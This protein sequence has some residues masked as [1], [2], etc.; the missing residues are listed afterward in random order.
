M[1]LEI[2]RRDVQGIVI[3]DLKG[4]LVFGAEDLELGTFLQSLLETGRKNI[5]LNL[6][7]VSHIDAAAEGSL[8]SNAEKFK[9]AGGRMVLLHVPPTH[10]RVD[11]LLV[12]DTAFETYQ[13]EPD[14]VNG[15]FPDRAVPQ[16]D[17]L[18]F[19]DQEAVSKGDESEKKPA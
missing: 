4:R 16:Y 6:R 17:L 7:D 5:I 11:E 18:E 12:L 10:A 15:F 3:L 13:N 1:P 19:L 14:A 9:S 8:L 2:Q